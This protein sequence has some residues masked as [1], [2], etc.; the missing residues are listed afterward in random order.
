[1]ALQRVVNVLARGGAQ[2]GHVGLAD[3]GNGR[4]HLVLVSAGEGGIKGS[5]VVVSRSNGVEAINGVRLGEALAMTAV[6][7]ARLALE[8]VERSVG[9]VAG[10]SLCEGLAGRGATLGVVVACASA[11]VVVDG[12]VVG[13]VA[14]D[15]GAGGAMEAGS[16]R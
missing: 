15:S 9:H 4:V 8:H 14:G 3:R 11:A 12:G 2:S 7:R 10:I 13:R 5:A 16:R 1:M 6:S